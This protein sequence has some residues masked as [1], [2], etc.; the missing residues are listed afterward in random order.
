[1]NHIFKKMFDRGNVP[2]ITHYEVVDPIGEPRVYPNVLSA[3]EDYVATMA[4]ATGKRVL[5]AVY[6]DG[7]T[8]TFMSKGVVQ[9]PML[10]DAPELFGMDDLQLTIRNKPHIEDYEQCS[11]AH[12]LRVFPASEITAWE[13]NG[14]TAVCPHCGVDAVLPDAQPEDK[15]RAMN[16]YMFVIRPNTG[17][18]G[19]L[20][21][22]MV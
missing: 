9:D 22:G 20:D 2:R 1:M 17:D 6:T 3:R 4:T 10:T 18:D 11:C 7:Q 5:R 19:T 8:F 13:D 15:L 16:A 14:T 12:C 21:G